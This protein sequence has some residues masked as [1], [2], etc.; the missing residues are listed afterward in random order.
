[1]QL[2]FGPVRLNCYTDGAVTTSA[3]TL[4]T[5]RLGLKV[6]PTLA[7][8]QLSNNSL[9]NVI[10]VLN[11]D[12]F[13]DEQYRPLLPIFSPKKLEIFLRKT[14]TLKRK[15]FIIITKTGADTDWIE[16][17]TSN[18]G[19][20]DA[21]SKSYSTFQ[22]PLRYFY[23]FSIDVIFRKLLKKQSFYKRSSR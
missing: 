16:R 18:K 4:A 17:T 9:Y 13:G 1:M 7:F 5:G 23:N 6:Q 10:F 14:F 21:T 8:L 20:Q 11:I 2:N 19:E 3:L 22:C 12:Q 15:E